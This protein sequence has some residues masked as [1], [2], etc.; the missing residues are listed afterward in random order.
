VRVTVDGPSGAVTIDT[1]VDATYDLRPPLP[2]L[3]A[4][5]LPFLAVGFLWTLR[6]VRRRHGRS[7]PNRP[8]RPLFLQRLAIQPTDLPI[9]Q[10]FLP[11]AS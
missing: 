1:R 10:P 5:L 4:Y 2:L 3:A 11:S 9:E 6:L 7:R 8:P